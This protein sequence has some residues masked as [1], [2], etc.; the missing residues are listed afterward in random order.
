L[1]NHEYYGHN[2]KVKRKNVSRLVGT[3][4]DRYIHLAVSS[5]KNKDIFRG[6]EELKADICSNIET[7]LDWRL[8]EPENGMYQRTKAAKGPCK[9]SIAHNTTEPP[10]Q[11]T[12]WG[13]TALMC[14][15]NILPRIVDIS[16]DPENLGRWVTQAVEGTGNHT[17]RFVSAYM[18]CKSRGDSTVYIQHQ[19]HFRRQKTDREPKQAFLEDLHKALT[20]WTEAGE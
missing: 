7:G 8:M 13:G 11:K 1:D 17:T 15:Q 4:V 10:K 5:E 6:C 12:Q 3:N 9:A 16:K 2:A 18:P 14:F 19:E 20:F